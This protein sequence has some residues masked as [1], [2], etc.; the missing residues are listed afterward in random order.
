MADGLVYL[1]HKDGKLQCVDLETGKDV[2]LERTHTGQ[3]RTSP[4]L[5]DGKLYYGSNDGWV[6]IVRAGPHVRAARFDRLRRRSDHGLAHRQPTA[7]STCGRTMPSTRSRPCRTGFSLSDPPGPWL[8]FT[9]DRACAASGQP[10]SLSVEKVVHALF[11]MVDRW[12]RRGFPGSTTAAS[13]GG[14]RVPQ[15]ARHRRRFSRVRV[16]IRGPRPGRGRRRSDL[17]AGR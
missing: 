10:L 11:P 6:T 13:C 17:R 14:R 5:A 8:G 3:H 4:L 9:A 12:T 2:Y 7:C 15:P 1:L 16:R